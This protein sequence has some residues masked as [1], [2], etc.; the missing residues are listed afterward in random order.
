MI[1]DNNTEYV[2]INCPYNNEE[3]YD[4]NNNNII[5]INQIKNPSNEICLKCKTNLQ[6][7]SFCEGLFPNKDYEGHRSIC[8]K[9]RSNI[10]IKG[11]SYQCN[12]C[13]KFILIVNIQ[14]HSRKCPDK[15]KEKNVIIEADPKV[16]CSFCHLDFTYEFIQ[17]HEKN[18]SE[19]K[20]QEYLLNE[21]YI[22][23]NCK[24]EHF[25]VQKATH[26]KVCKLLKA[27]KE[28]I[29]KKIKELESKEVYP[30]FWSKN[31]K[32]YETINNFLSVCELQWNCNEYNIINNLI[33]DNLHI[34]RGTHF[35]NSNFGSSY[36]INVTSAFISNIQRVQ[37]KNLYLE[38][39]KE[40]KNVQENF[41]P[42][43]NKFTVTERNYFYLGAFDN[44]DYTR[45]NGFE[46]SMFLNNDV[47]INNGPYFYN[48]GTGLYFTNSFVQLKSIILRV[49]LNMCQN[50]YFHGNYFPM[51]SIDFKVYI[52]FASVIIGDCWVPK[53]C[54]SN[55]NMYKFNQPPI[56]WG[57]VHFDSVRSMD[58]STFV[59][60]DK[61]K[62]YP[63]YE[64]ELTLRYNMISNYVGPFIN[65]IPFKSVPPIIRGRF[66]NDENINNNK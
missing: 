41:Q 29:E 5:D 34:L 18:C 37:N 64:I 62:T 48:F 30:K 44:N 15:K 31:I 16:Q 13:K 52:Y 46:N 61:K 19:L 36:G 60:Y 21:K 43:I 25:Q 6:E 40:K 8:G 32:K 39:S 53:K 10:L 58:G 23:G 38:Y 7:C 28:E 17:E 11:D 51:N 50:L 12:F 24:E 55:R 42:L 4:N 2:D 33:R 47:Y 14:D 22:C 1:K 63:T 27:R 65:P 26:D 66:N 56:K 3:N 35:L 49:F 59:V 57:N 45:L 20:T 54:Y 9:L